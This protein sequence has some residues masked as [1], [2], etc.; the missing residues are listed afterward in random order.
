MKLNIITYTI[1]VVYLV[2]LW[3]NSEAQSLIWAHEKQN[4][5]SF[6]SP[7]AYDLNSDGNLDIVV[8]FGLDDDS[9][10][11]NGAMAL[12]GI[13]GNELWE[14]LDPENDQ[15]FST[16]I[17][18]DTNNDNQMDVI[19]AGRGGTLIALDGGNGD[20]L[21]SLDYSQL[22]IE[23]SIKM[24]VYNG[25]FISDEN[26][27]DIDDIV[28]TIGGTGKDDARIPGVL[29]VISGS[30]GHV[31]SV[32]E[33]PDQKETYCSPLIMDVGADGNLDVI[34]G[35]GGETIQGNLWSVPL[36]DLLES[37][38][39]NAQIIEEGIN[40]GFIAPPSFAD[41][42]NDNVPDIL[43]P[44]MD[45]QLKVRDGVDLSILWEVSHDN[46]EAYTQPSIGHLNND[47][48][49][50]VYMKFHI[51]EWP[52]YSSAIFQQID[53]ANGN[54]MSTDTVI[55]INMLSGVFNDSNSDG[56]D[57]IIDTRF[58]P[59]GNLEL[60]VHD[61]STGG[62]TI[63]ESQTGQMNFASTPLVTDIDNNGL[64][65]I[66][67]FHLEGTMGPQPG[68]P[69]FIKRIEMPGELNSAWSG[70]LGNDTDGTYKENLTTAIHSISN[71]KDSD[72]SVVIIQDKLFWE[73]NREV[74]D[75]KIHLFS[76]NGN[77]V[78]KKSVTEN[79]GTLETHKLISGVY[80]LLLLDE[81]RS[82]VASFVI[83]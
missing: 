28:I 11:P 45:G 73:L 9:P 10:N 16:P 65:D 81:G 47:E 22:N 23:D 29:T 52:Q 74:L 20:L 31:I 3:N 79:N 44:T 36:G 64:F 7:K 57:E 37:N 13:T 6:S 35:S 60:F 15:I 62:T 80:Y 78:E 71:H 14:Y 69:F 53:G 49:P 17:F 43:I 75:A 61:P 48:I 39:S 66:I 25:Q 21:W 68:N 82:Y 38:M 12:D 51:G 42:N 46:S 56:L 72:L 76:S 4:S 2:F 63:L 34:F 77:L 33:M 40:K 1:T 55:G 26:N 59:N 41:M 24:N 58:L 8:G 54:S 19:M 67:Y 32:G 5:Y 70:Y 50:D 27:D 30:D 18:L 83:K